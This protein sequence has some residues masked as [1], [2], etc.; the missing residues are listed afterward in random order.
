[1]CLWSAVSALALESELQSPARQPAVGAAAT[2]RPCPR[3]HPPLYVP[4]QRQTPP[5]IH[6]V[7]TRHV[8]VTVVAGCWLLVA[9]VRINVAALV[10]T[11]QPTV[12]VTPSVTRTPTRTITRTATV[13]VTPTISVTAGPSATPLPRPLPAWAQMYGDRTLSSRSRLSGP[14]LH[15]GAV[16]VD[17]DTYADSPESFAVTADGMVLFLVP[18]QGKT[19]LYGSNAQLEQQWEYPLPYSPCGMPTLV[20]DLVILSTA[21]ELLAL[22]LSGGSGGGGGGG[23]APTKAWSVPQGNTAQNTA[24]SCPTV[25]LNRTVVVVDSMAGTATAHHTS[26]GAV[27]WQTELPAAAPQPPSADDD[28]FDDDQPTGLSFTPAIGGAQADTVFVTGLHGSIAR[29][30]ADDGAVVWNVTLG[31]VRAVTRDDT[32]VVATHTALVGLAASDGSQRWSV[33]T[34]DGVI[35]VAVGSNDWVYI[36]SAS[37]VVAVNRTGDHM[38]Q[39]GACEGNNDDGYSQGIATPSVLD[40]RGVLYFGTQSYCTLF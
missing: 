16:R 23:G 37:N 11:I 35:G 18:S 39:S 7:L 21:S 28:I 8:S 2:I 24:P 6:L 12:S 14:S 30:R 5:D 4:L 10:T 22:R 33:P 34:P 40:A 15:T 29:L 25:G 13:S 3:G 19:T 26:S 36:T 17:E 32:V 20:G 27:V 31:H 9:A 38:W 1:M